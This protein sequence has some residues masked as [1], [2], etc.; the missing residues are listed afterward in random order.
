MTGKPSSSTECRGP[1]SRSNWPVWSVARSRTRRNDGGPDPTAE[2]AEEGQGK[3]H[4]FRVRCPLAHDRWAGRGLWVVRDSGKMHDRRITRD[5]LE[6]GD[7]ERQAMVIGKEP[8][9]RP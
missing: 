3:H 6:F 7:A 2:M 1:T 8:R 5:R 9:I 4:R